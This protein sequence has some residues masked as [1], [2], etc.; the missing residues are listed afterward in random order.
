MQATST[1]GER[2]CLYSVLGEKGFLGAGG[3]GEGPCETQTGVSGMCLSTDQLSLGS[4][5]ALVLEKSGFTRGWNASGSE[6]EPEPSFH[7]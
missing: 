2:E 3:P 4:H 5:R 7:R 1:A 6:L